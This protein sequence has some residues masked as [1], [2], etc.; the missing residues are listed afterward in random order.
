M[1]RIFFF[2]SLYS[3]AAERKQRSFYMPPH[4]G[5]IAL[6]LHKGG[7]CNV[8][9]IGSGARSN[10]F[11]SRGL[12]RANTI[13]NSSVHVGQR[14]HRE[15]LAAG[16]RAGMHCVDAKEALAS[17]PVTGLIPRG[18]GF[19][20]RI[21]LSSASRAGVAE[22]LWEQTVSRLL[23]DAIRAA[24]GEGRCC[25]HPVRAARR[26]AAGRSAAGRDSRCARCQMP[27]AFN[28]LISRPL[29]PLFVPAG[30]QQLASRLS[31]RAVTF[32]SLAERQAL[33]VCRTDH[34]FKRVWKFLISEC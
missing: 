17:P 26:S 19:S 5:L 22:L 10:A 11:H 4:P 28:A 9:V 25:S 7:R 29:E 32:W 1:T 12:K 2:F 20:S 8:L 34:G 24:G 31:P 15:W 21:E 30:P 23:L 6:R 33:V 3:K 27:E 14:R 18:D 16:Q 13:V